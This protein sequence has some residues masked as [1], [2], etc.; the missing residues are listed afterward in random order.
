MP[1]FK[2]NTP[3]NNAKKLNYS[4]GFQPNQNSKEEYSA[5]FLKIQ[6]L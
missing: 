6:N 4:I 2:P 5:D 3:V 1:I